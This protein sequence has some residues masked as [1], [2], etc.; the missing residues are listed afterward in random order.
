[1][2]AGTASA[3][4]APAT[5]ASGNT[6]SVSGA[7]VSGASVSTAP[8]SNGRTGP[9]EAEIAEAAYFKHLNRR[10]AQGDEFRDWIEAERELRERR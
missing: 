6:T 9:S 10:G 7:S 8:S 2:A 3:S 1:M 5:H 4:D